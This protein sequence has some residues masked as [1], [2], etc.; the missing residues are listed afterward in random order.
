MKKMSFSVVAVVV[1]MVI[2]IAGEA[3]AYLPSDRGFSSSATISGDSVDY[4]VN[5]NGAF[6]HQAILMDDG[7]MSGVESVRMYYDPSY[8]SNVNEQRITAVGS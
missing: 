1:I 3:Y 8:A 7:G 4:S 2:I 5:A 6:V